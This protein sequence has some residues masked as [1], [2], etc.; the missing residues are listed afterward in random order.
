MDPILPFDT[1]QRTL[2]GQSAPPGITLIHL[3]SKW[4]LSIDCLL[5]TDLDAGGI[6]A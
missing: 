6:A 3:F 2:R 1:I 5:G 4:L